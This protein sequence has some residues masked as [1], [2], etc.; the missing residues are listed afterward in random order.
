V[1][2]LVIDTIHH[3]TGI[4]Q[5]PW[6]FSRLQDNLGAYNVLNDIHYKFY[7]FHANGL[8]ALLFVYAC[9]RAHYGMFTAPV[10]WFD[11]GFA[12]LSLVLFVGSRDLLHKYH[13]R[14]SQLLGSPQSAPDPRPESESPASPACE[15]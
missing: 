7:L 8:V 6:N 9:R 4:R 14:V 12:L 10:G 15:N 1:R 5:P 11:L 13:A 3:C 2:W